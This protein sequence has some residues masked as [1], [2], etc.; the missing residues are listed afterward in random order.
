MLAIQLQN[1][2]CQQVAKRGPKLRTAVEDSDTQGVLLFRI[3]TAYVFRA[4][5]QLGYW[6]AWI[7]L[8]IHSSSIMQPGK[9][10]PRRIPE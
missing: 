2:N 4:D 1:P 3:P 10:Q 5:G 9:K 8:S 7:N 6:L